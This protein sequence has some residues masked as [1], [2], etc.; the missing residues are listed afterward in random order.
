MDDPP[1]PFLKSGEMFSFLRLLRNLCIFKYSVKRKVNGSAKCTAPSLSTQEWTFEGPCGLLGFNL[2]R[3]FK[4]SW[5][6][7]YL[8]SKKVFTVAFAFSYFVLLF[9]KLE[10]PSL[11]NLLF[12]VFFWQNK[13]GNID[14]IWIFQNLVN[15]KTCFAIKMTHWSNIEGFFQPFFSAIPLKTS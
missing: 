15:Q 7:M 10:S 5:L 12:N 2:I 1:S 3:T 13:H 14:F 6:V 9:P 11:L 8:K 4:H